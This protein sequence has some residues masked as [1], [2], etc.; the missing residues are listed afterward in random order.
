MASKSGKRREPE[1]E[2]V[3]ISF[4]LPVGTRDRLDEL[5]K[6]TRVPKSVLIREGLEL[7]FE[8]RDPIPPLLR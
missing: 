6:R 1:Q 8:K 7:L 2:A 4:S 5:S 3:V